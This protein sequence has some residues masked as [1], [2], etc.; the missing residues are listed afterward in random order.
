MQ[1]HQVQLIILKGFK[2]VTFF[3]LPK[4]TVRME[5]WINKIPTLNL[6]VSGKTRVCIKHFDDTNIK[7]SDIL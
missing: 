5:E 2:P 1:I 7:R 4:D 3:R 6:K